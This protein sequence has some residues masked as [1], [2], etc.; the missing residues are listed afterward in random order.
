M[1]LLKSGNKPLEP[2]PDF[3][4]TTK[5]NRKTSASPVSLQIRREFCLVSRRLTF[6]DTQRPLHKQS[7]PLQTTQSPTPSRQMPGF[8]ERRSLDGVR[9]DSLPGGHSPRVPHIPAA[10]RVSVPPATF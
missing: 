7:R 6:S 3:V 9:R 10:C 5:K 4:S 1:Q 8:P 2:A